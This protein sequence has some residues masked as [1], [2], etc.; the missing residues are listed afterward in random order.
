MWGFDMGQGRGGGAGSEMERR[1]RPGGGEGG[2]RGERRHVRD[3]WQER[4]DG[5]IGDWG[6][7]GRD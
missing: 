6:G 4:R 2:G 5:V 3:V 7:K 1:Q